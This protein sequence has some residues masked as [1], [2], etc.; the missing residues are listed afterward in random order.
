M[1]KAQSNAAAKYSPY[2]VAFAQRV[3]AIFCAMYNMFV[4]A[5]GLEMIYDVAGRLAAAA[6]SPTEWASTELGKIAQFADD[7][8]QDRVRK[9]LARYTD[10]SLQ[11][12]GV[13]KRIREERTAFLATYLRKNKKP[14]IISRA[15]GL[16]SLCQPESLEASAKMRRH[17]KI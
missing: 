13:F 16:A 11:D 1:K 5:D 12:K 6:A 9:V 10:G 14:S 8:S 17:C 7:R 4:D 2:G 3:G 15:M